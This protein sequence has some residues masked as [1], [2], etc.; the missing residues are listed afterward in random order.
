MKAIIFDVDDTLYN[1]ADIFAGAYHT[2]FGSRFELDLEKLFVA[3]RRRSDEVFELSQTGQITM[4]EMYIYRIQKAFGDLGAAI[5]EK[6]SLLFQEQYAENQRNL[7]VPALTAKLLQKCRDC[8][9]VTGV[10]TNGPSGH[11]W[12]KVRALA[13]EQWIPKDNIFV[14]GDWGA[15]KPDPAIFRR[16]QEKLGL[17]PDELLFVGDSYENDVVGAKR[18]GWSVLWVNR[19]KRDISGLEIQPDYETGSER[20]MCEVIESVLEWGQEL[21]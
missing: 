15:A 9:I 8:H 1:Q 17:Q 19:R 7:K 5:T 3:S 14:S 11:Q 12:K 13:L 6:E 21:K 2:V 20:E 10:I 16:A 18:A 4:E